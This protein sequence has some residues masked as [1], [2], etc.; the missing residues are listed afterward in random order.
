MLAEQRENLRRAAREEAVWDDA[1]RYMLSENPKFL[2]DIWN[3]DFFINL[4][5]DTIA[6]VAPDGHVVA[7]RALD[8]ATNQL[9]PP[10][11]ALA[12]ALAPGGSIASRVATA[13]FAISLALLGGTIYAFGTSPTLPS[14]GSGSGTPM[15]W[16]YL[17][18]AIGKPFQSQLS[19]LGGARASLRV[20][21]DPVVGGS[22]EVRIDASDKQLL[23]SRF[24]ARHVGA[25]HSAEVELLSRRPAHAGA[26]RAAWQ[27]RSTPV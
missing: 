3:A 10:P 17:F 6:F 23:G 5:I 2:D 1:Y 25:G 20:I 19:E 26:V 18:R 4:P 15:S 13:E 24:I 16:A 7:Q 9:G 22:T 27:P 12:L 11:P 21:A 8:A 14:S